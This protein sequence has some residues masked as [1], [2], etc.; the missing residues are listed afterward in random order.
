[1]PLR[2]APEAGPRPRLFGPHALGLGPRQRRGPGARPP[3]AA[4]ER[5]SEQRPGAPEGQEAPRGASIAP[6]LARTGF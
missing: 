3:A 2:S 5:L 6:G 1:M 4:P